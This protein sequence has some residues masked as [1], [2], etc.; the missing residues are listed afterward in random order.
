[1]WRW[2][3]FQ[4]GSALLVLPDQ[5]KALSGSYW[6]SKVAGRDQLRYERRVDTAETV[7]V[8][9]YEIGSGLAL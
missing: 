5:V 3:A 8:L 1:M 9:L 6:G 4:R 2:Q 7:L